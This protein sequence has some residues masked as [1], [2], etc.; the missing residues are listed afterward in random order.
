MRLRLARLRLLILEKALFTQDGDVLL[1]GER[2]WRSG[3]GLR[4][5]FFES[6]V[7]KGPVELIVEFTFK[8]EAVIHTLGHLVLLRRELL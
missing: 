4:F 5:Y 6:S 2:G 8:F 3:L 1:C 7:K